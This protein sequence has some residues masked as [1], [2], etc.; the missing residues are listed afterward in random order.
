MFKIKEYVVV[1][2]LAEAFELNQKKRS[3]VLGG[4]GWLRLGNKEISTAIDLSELGLDTIVENEDE[5]QI[6]CMT[7]LRDLELHEGLNE[8][9]NGAIKECVRHIV[10]VQFRNGATV[11]GSIYARF[12]FSDILSCL[13]TLDTYVDLYEKGLLPLSEFVAMPYDR[14]ILTRIIIKKDKRRVVYQSKRASATDIPILAVA[15]AKKEDTYYVSIGARPKRAVLC[16]NERLLDA[17][18]KEEIVSFAKEICS[19]VEFGSNMRGSEEYRH[20][21][22]E[23]FVKRGIQTLLGGE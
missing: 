2:S 23:V 10:G 4:T 5:F 18:K 11:G 14:D 20:H 15:V 8:Y 12:G 19:N 9:F 13:L 16:V 6:G 3:V 1:K 7:S 17:S 22:A 21:L